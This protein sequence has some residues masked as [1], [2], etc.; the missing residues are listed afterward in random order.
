[1]QTDDTCKS[2]LAAVDHL[3]SAEMAGLCGVALHF[4]VINDIETPVYPVF[5]EDGAPLFYERHEASRS[6][7]AYIQL[8]TFGR[9]DGMFVGP[10]AEENVLAFFL[11][12]VQK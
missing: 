4:A 10:L 9:R 7:G 12:D 5:G 2:R 8:S 11:V 3:L 1:M 6:A